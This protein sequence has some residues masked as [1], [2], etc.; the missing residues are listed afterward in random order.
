VRE[1]CGEYEWKYKKDVYESE[2]PSHYDQVE[3]KKE[4]TLYG[5]F[6]QKKTWPIVKNTNKNPK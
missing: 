6:I 4:K 2:Q 3:R 5:N 1:M